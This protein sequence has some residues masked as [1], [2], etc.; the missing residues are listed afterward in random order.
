MVKKV[1][2]QQQEAEPVPLQVLRQ[3]AG[4]SRAKLAALLGVDPSTIY[5]CEKGFTEL[6]LTCEGWQ[7]LA[8]T[9]GYEKVS[10]MPRHL[11]RAPSQN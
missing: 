2:S 9:F 7:T 8:K 10:E 6:K 1:K 3:E 11:G 4:L 5:A